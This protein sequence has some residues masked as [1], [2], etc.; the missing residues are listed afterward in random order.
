MNDTR[1]YRRSDLKSMVQDDKQARLLFYRRGELHYQT[2]DGFQFVV[3]TH[4]TGDGVFGAEMKT[5][6]LM[7]WSVG[8]WRSSIP[9]RSNWSGLS[10]SPA[11]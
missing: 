1:L 6:A 7:R 5:I 4:D 8:P 3:P 10:G 2:E 9:H 11:A